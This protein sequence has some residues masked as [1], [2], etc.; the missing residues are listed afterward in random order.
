MKADEPH[1]FEPTPVVPMSIPSVGTTLMSMPPMGGV[2]GKTNS[3]MCKICNRPEN[4]RLHLPVKD[5][6][7]AE[8]WG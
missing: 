6:L 2:V 5:E 1:V 8:H 7:A 4:D 3:K